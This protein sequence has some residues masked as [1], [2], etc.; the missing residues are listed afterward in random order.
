MNRP[1]PL[2]VKAEE[3]EV[4]RSAAKLIN[5]RIKQYKDRFSVQDDLDLVIMCCLE[6][7]TD[8]LNQAARTKTGI[9]YAGEELEKIDTALNAAILNTE[10]GTPA[11]PG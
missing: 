5:D 8:N 3:E 11:Q 10:E 4:V 2:L 9:R 7:A 1:Y 6:L